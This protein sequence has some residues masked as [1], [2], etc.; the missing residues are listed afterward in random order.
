M[1]HIDP[2]VV[3]RWIFISPFMDKSGKKRT[4]ENP[5]FVSAMIH[6]FVEI[7]MIVLH[8]L[9]AWNKS[10][11]SRT[12]CPNIYVYLFALIFQFIIS[13]AMFPFILSLLRKNL[14]VVEN[15]WNRNSSGASRAEGNLW[16]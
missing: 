16:T 7:V 15:K 1:A 4:M 14:D 2:F 5:A 11:M 8:L 10:W 12:F 13:G 9:P 3:L 6:S